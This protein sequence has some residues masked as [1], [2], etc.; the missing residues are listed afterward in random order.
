MR[1][2]TLLAL[3][4][5]S[6]PALADGFVP[7]RPGFA[8]NP[9]AVDQGHLLGEVGFSSVDLGV[10]KAVTAPSLL[11][12]YG[13]IRDWELRLDL[14]VNG[15]IPD[16]GDSEFG[17]G[18][19]GIGL[20]YAVPIEAFALGVVGRVALPA[21]QEGYGADDLEYLI[22]ASFALP[23]MGPVGISGNLGANFVDAGDDLELVWLG[24]LALGGGIGPVGL[25]GQYIGY[26]DGDAGLS[27]GV[28]AGVNFSPAP[29]FQID[30]MYDVGVGDDGIPDQL[31]A[32]VAFRI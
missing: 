24:S 5:L 13:L 30:L 1:Y 25:Y 2:L 9:A 20:K 27:S 16:K 12:R 3:A 28:G 22:N 29:N 21:L 15:V 32:G 6:G 19:P 8:D 14:P 26:Y 11:A 18:A 31:Q 4:G 10:A 17:L 23:S 7:D